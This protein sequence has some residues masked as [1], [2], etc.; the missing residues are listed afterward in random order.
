MMAHQ[1]SAR[2]SE[3]GSAIIY[4]FVGIALF[5]A[6]MF[7]F[8]R[9]SSQNTSA[10][11]TQ[12]ANIT[13]SEILSYRQSLEASVQRLISKGCSENE[14]NFDTSL[15][16]GY[17]NPD[18][19]PDK[20]CDVFDAAGGRAKYIYPS[21]SSDTTY[22]AGASPGFKKYGI[23]GN[24]VVTDVGTPEPELIIWLMT[25]KAVC[26]AINASIGQTTQDEAFGDGIISV[27]FIGDFAAIGSAG[28][29]GDDAYPEAISTGCVNRPAYA[30]QYIFYSVLLAR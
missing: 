11:T 10:L 27:Q 24:M 30:G 13:A 17:T 14:L 18:A 26:D 9:G 12:Q 20:S 3:T 8:S 23:N 7:M 5:A 29:I 2:S 28:T 15:E 22:A 1:H 25:N 6:L 4:V 16:T 21:S 19:R